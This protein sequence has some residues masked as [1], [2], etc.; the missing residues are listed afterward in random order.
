MEPSVTLPSDNHLR[1]WSIERGR[2]P[3]I[4]TAIHDGHAVWP[5]L[6]AKMALDAPGRLRE[7]DPFTAQFIIDMPNR[8]VVH[9]SRFEVDLNRAT[10]GA[11]YLHP[12]QAWGLNVWQTQPSDAE[13][14]ALLRQHQSY[15]A[16]LRHV[17]S[18]IVAE[19]GH[20]VLLDMH[21][22][23]HRRNGVSAPPTPQR[24]A[25][26][27]NIGTFS[28]QRDRWAHVLE[29]FM[30][31]L[32]RHTVSGKPIDVRENIAFEGKGEQTR[33]VHEHF[34][35]NGCAI[36]VEFKKIFMDEWTGAPDHSAIADLRA[37]VQASLPILEQALDTR[38]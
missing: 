37:A 21:S 30:D 18:D 23:N 36:A 11:I 29:P 3:L 20:F 27:I 9:R 16:T 6:A 35:E 4:G 33:F 13:V 5:H 8:I 26:D 34:P 14:A 19:H 15:Y 12:D 38:S 17:L 1:L 25:P 2:S 28:M 31:S 10:D 7:E 24:D 32:R 22:Y